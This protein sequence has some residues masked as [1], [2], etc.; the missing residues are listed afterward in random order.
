MPVLRKR[1]L[2]APISKLPLNGP[3]AIHN[4]KTISGVHWTI[5]PPKDSGVG[6]DEPMD[7]HGYVKISSE[8]FPKPTQNLKWASDVLDRMIHE[9]NVCSFPF[10]TLR[11]H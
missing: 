8:G 4:F 1:V 3:K 2:V 10:P 11:G 5:D 9:A 6:K 7:E